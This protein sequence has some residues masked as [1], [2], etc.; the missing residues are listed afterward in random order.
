MVGLVQLATLTEL[1]VGGEGLAA[2]DGG[3]VSVCGGLHRHRYVYTSRSNHVQL[4]LLPSVD[5]RFLLKFEGS[6]MTLRTFSDVKR[7][8]FH[9]QSKFT[10]KTFKLSNGSNITYSRS[11]SAFEITCS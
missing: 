7:R 3:S 11:T 6:S 10:L 5:M 1:P 9:Q 4:R 8:N 2:V